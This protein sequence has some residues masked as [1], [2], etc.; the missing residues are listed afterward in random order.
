ML[1][2]EDFDNPHVLHKRSTSPQDAQKDQTSYPPKPVAPGRALFRARALQLLSSTF[3]SCALREHMTTRVS[4]PLILSCAFCE[5]E[6]HLS[7]PSPPFS[8]RA[9]REHGDRPSYPTSFFSILL[10]LRA[11]TSLHRDACTR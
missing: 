1:V 2:R 6:G 9:L 5:Q 11:R 10:N 4:F 3:R 7:A 8:S